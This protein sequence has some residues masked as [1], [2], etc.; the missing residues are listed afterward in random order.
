MGSWSA[1]VDQTIALMADS[2]GRYTIPALTVKWWDTQANQLRTATLPAHVDHPSRARQRRGR[3]LRPAGARG[4]V[5]TVAACPPTRSS[6]SA[7]PQ[8]AP[9]RSPSEWQWISIGLA[10]VWLATLGAWLWSRRSRAAPRP[11]RPATPTSSHQLRPDPAKERAAAFRAACQANDPQAARAHLLAWASALWGAAP[12]GINAVA[13]RIGDAA[14]AELLRDLDRACYAGG[15]WQG[16][17]LAAA[18][19]EL[20]A[21]SGK[22]G[23]QRDSLAPLYP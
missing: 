5:A 4:A 12:A 11:V 23:R 14:V 1:A 8:P 6:P 18:L 13:T 21:P 9:A 15:A 7:A 2:P 16:N 3:S 17:A 19:T 10:V 22:T 20:R